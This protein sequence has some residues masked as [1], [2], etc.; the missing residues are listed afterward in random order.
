MLV[1]NIMDNDQ[2]R[3]SIL[4]QF[5]NSMYTG[6]GHPNVRNNPE[7]AGILE[8][9]I[10]ANVLYLWDKG[11]IEGEK[12]VEDGGRSFVVTSDITSR[13]MDVVES[14]VNRSLSEI[15]PDVSKE[16]KEETTPNGKLDKL[17]EACK[18]ATP[19]AETVMSI[20]R[21]I[22]SGLH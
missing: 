9:V 19:V 13:G 12:V 2:I 14:I 22:L 5:Y 8:P 21:L 6:Q 17:Y 11:L 16:I 15:K 10:E 1:K 4:R 18:K 3:L 7:L 20:V